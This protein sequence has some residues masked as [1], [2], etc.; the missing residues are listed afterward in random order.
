MHFWIDF[1]ISER[2]AS[3]NVGD[4]LRNFKI[5]SKMHLRTGW[6]KSWTAPVVKTYETNLIRIPNVN[7][8][9]DFN[10]FFN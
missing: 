8:A 7:F 10:Y 6:F 2:I 3:A 1:E 9:Q 4:P 5:D